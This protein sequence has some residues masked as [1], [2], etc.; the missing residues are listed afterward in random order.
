MDMYWSLRARLQKTHVEIVVA[1]RLAVLRMSFSTFSVIVCMNP[2]ASSMPPNMV[3]LMISHIVFI[4][5]PI[6]FVE[7]SF[8]SIGLGAAMS[9]WED[10]SFIGA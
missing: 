5:P 8:S 7:A 4:I 2:P 1:T 10:I 6:P 3:T 9:M